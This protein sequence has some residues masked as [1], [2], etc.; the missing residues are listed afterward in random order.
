MVE[1]KAPGPKLHFSDVDLPA[2]FHE[3]NRLHFDGLL[4]EPRIIWHPRL[5]TSAGRFIPG[6]HIG[7]GILTGRFGLK[8]LERPTQIEVATYLLEL[9]NAEH[10]IRD[11]LGH[12]MIHYWLWE[13]GRPYGHTAEFHAKMREMGVSRYNPVPKLTGTR[14][15]YRCPSC[16]RQWIRKRRYTRRVACLVCCK[17]HAGGEFSEKFLLERVVVETLGPCSKQE[18]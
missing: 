9:P 1:L 12:E 14:Y 4:A 6:K 18:K 8:A 11:T 16:N 5:R 15:A 2:M 3:W 13:R 7:R 17:K 10:H